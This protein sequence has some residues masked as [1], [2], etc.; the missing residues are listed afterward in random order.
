MSY[1][2]KLSPWVIYRQLANLQRIEV[3]RFRWRNDAEEY[4]KVVQ[5]MV[6]QARF[7]IVYEANPSINEVQF[8]IFANEDAV[9]HPTSSNGLHHRQ[10]ICE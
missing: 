8:E 3:V 7:E 5:R 10:L 6:P 4:L 9:A 1:Q 2:E